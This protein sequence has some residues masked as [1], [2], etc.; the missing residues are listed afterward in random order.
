MERKF[1]CDELLKVRRHGIQTDFSETM[2][3]LVESLNMY[4]VLAILDFSWANNEPGFVIK[5]ETH[6]SAIYRG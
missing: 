4:G 1:L 6:S 2:G 3:V 5:R